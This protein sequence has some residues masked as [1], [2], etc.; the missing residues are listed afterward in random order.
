M[1]RAAVCMGHNHALTSVHMF[2]K[3]AEKLFLKVQ[4]KSYALIVYCIDY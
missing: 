4:L 1:H 2:I 3:V